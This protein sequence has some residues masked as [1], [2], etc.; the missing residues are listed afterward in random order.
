MSRKHA[1]TLPEVLASLAILGIVALLM[2]AAIRSDE[3]TAQLYNAQYDKVYEDV[4]S[5]SKMVLTLDRNDTMKFGAEE[6][7]DGLRAAFADRL[8]IADTWDHGTGWASSE[9][10]ALSKIGVDKGDISGVT[11]SNGTRI[12]FVSAN[13][14]SGGASGLAS[15]MGWS[16][17]N[18]VGALAVD[19]NGSNPRNSLGNDQSLIPL[20][21]DGVKQDAR[22]GQLAAD[23]TQSTVS[24]TDLSDASKDIECNIVGGE[25]VCSCTRVETYNGQEFP[26]VNI[27]GQCKSDCLNIARNP[28]VNNANAM[29]D[30][31]REDGRCYSCKMS[32]EHECNAK[33]WIF[34]DV[35][36]EC[37]DPTAPCEEPGFERNQTTGACECALTPETCGLAPGEELPE[38][39]CA[40]C[41]AG[42]LVGVNGL[43]VDENEVCGED[44][45]ANANRTGCECLVMNQ[46]CASGF[47]NTDTC[48][49]ECDA[50][51]GRVSNDMTNGAAQCACEGNTACAEHNGTYDD[52]NTCSCNCPAPYIPNGA[53]GAA[54]ACVC[55]MTASGCAAQNGILNDMECKCEPCPVGTYPENG[56]CVKGDN[57]SGDNGNGNGDNG[58]QPGTGGGGG[59]YLPGVCPTKFG[60]SFEIKD[61]ITNVPRWD[62][63]YYC[64]ERGY[65][66]IT[67][68][69][70]L[71][72]RKRLFN[73]C[74]VSS[75]SHSNKTDTVYSCPS[76]S[77]DNSLLEKL[78][79]DDAQINGKYYMLSSERYQYDECEDC[80]WDDTMSGSISHSDNEFH[81]SPYDSYYERYY[82]GDDDEYY[83]EEEVGVAICVE[84]GDFPHEVKNNVCLY[85][86]AANCNA[87]DI[88]ISDARGLYNIRNNLSANYCLVADID[89]AAQKNKIPKYDEAKGWDPIEGP[90]EY[91]YYYDEF[92]YCEAYYGFSGTFNGNGH[93]IS[94]L[95]INRP[96][97]L[98]T[99][100]FGYVARGATIKNLGLANVNVSGA[101]NTG[102]LAGNNYGN[103]T[104]TYVTGKVV[105][106]RPYIGGLVGSNGGVINSSVSAANVESD[107][108]A[109]GGIVGSNFGGETMNSYFTGT[110]TSTSCWIG[111]VAGD[112]YYGELKNSY[113]IGHVYADCDAGGVQGLVTGATVKDS[114]SDSTVQNIPAIGTNNG[115]VTNVRA[116]TTSQ[117][118][119]SKTSRN[120]YKN[121]PSDI[122]CFN[123][124][125]YPVLKDMPKGTPQPSGANSCGR[126]CSCP[127]ASTGTYDECTCIGGAPLYESLDNIC[128]TCAQATSDATPYWNSETHQ[129][130]ACPADKP[131]YNG[132][133][134]LPCSDTAFPIQQG[135]K[136]VSCAS[137]D[138][139]KPYWN[140]TEC[141]ACPNGMDCSN[142]VN[143][144]KPECPAIYK[145]T[146]PTEEGNCG[147]GYIAITTPEQLAQ[148]GNCYPSNAN[149]CL[150]NSIDL[151]NFGSTYDGGE[152][153]LPISGYQGTFDGN[154]HAIKNLYM[155]RH[156]INGPFYGLFEQLRNSTIKN[157]SLLNEY[158]NIIAIKTRSNSVGYIGGLAGSLST[159]TTVERVY[160]DANITLNSMVGEQQSMAGGVAAGTSSSTV[161][162]NVHTDGSVTVN[163]T[164]GGQNSFAG[165]IIG[166]DGGA[167]IS[168][169]RS[170]VNV[171]SVSNG[172]NA[173]A[174][175]IAGW[176]IA[177]NY[178]KS[179]MVNC[180]A[181]GKINGRYGGGVVGYY[182][183]YG[184]NEGGHIE[185]SLYFDTQATETAKG[186]GN[187]KSV[188]A[189]T[190]LTTAQS[191]KTNLDDV[192]TGWSTTDWCF[193]CGDY[194][195]LKNMPEGAP[196]GSA[197]ALQCSTCPSDSWDYG[198]DSSGNLQCDCSFNPQTYDYVYNVS[199]NSTL[200]R[201]D[202]FCPAES[203]GE[204]PDCDC[205]ANTGNELYDNY[206]NYCTSCYSMYWHYSPRWN[207]ETKQCEACP[208]ETPFFSEWDNACITCADYDINTPVWDSN[209]FY[210][211]SCYDA[212]NSRPYWTGT[213]CVSCASV[214]ASKP[215]WNTST[216]EC[217][218]CELSTFGEKSYWNG[219]ECVSCE[220]V[221]STKTAW[222]GSECVSCSS[223]NSSKPGWLINAC[224]T[225]PDSLYPV[226]QGDACVS[227][228]SID[229][230]TPYWNGTECVACLDGVNCSGDVPKLTGETPEGNCGSGYI[231]ITSVAQLAVIGRDSRYPLNGNYCVMND[232]DISSYSESAVG[233]WL[234]IGTSVGS[235]TGTLDGNGHTIN[236]LYI[237]R[238]YP[239]VE[240]Q[241]LIGKTHNAT[242]KN[243][244]LQNVNIA[245]AWA[246]VGGLVGS[247]DST[248]NIINS[249]VSGS[250]TG[251][252][253]VGGLVGGGYYNI[254]NSYST[255]TVV[256]HGSRGGGLVGEL[257]GNIENSFST[258]SVTGV[259]YL[260]GLVGWS[261]YRQATIKDSYATGDIT[262]N[263][264][265]AYGDIGGLVGSIRDGG[266][267]QN[268]YSTGRVVGQNS[269]QGGLLG[270]KNATVTNSYY[271][272]E[273]S[274]QTDTGKGTP[275][276]TA[277]MKSIAADNTYVGWSEDV[278]CFGCSDYPHLK[279]MPEGAPG[280]TL[281]ARSCGSCP[282]GSKGTYPSCSC[283]EGYEYS[284]FA[285][286]CAV[287]C[288]NNGS[289]Y[290]YPNCDCSG[291]DGH[292]RYDYVTN[293]CVSCAVYGSDLPIWNGSECISCASATSAL[294][295]YWDGTQCTNVPDGMEYDEEDDIIRLTAPTDKGYCDA[296]YIAIF[297]AHQM[298]LIGQD[299]R[300][301]L[302]DR[303]C[304]MNDINLG[305]YSS[306]TANGWLPIGDNKNAFT[307]TFDGNMQTISGL[308]I[309]RPST[310]YNG[311]FGRTNNATLKNVIIANADLASVGG[312]YS[313]ILVGYST[314]GSINNVGTSGSIAGA[315]SYV[316]GLVGATSN[317][318]IQKSY[319]TANVT[320]GTYV[321]G[322]IGRYVSNSIKYCY[323]TGDVEGINQ[324]GGFVGDLS[325]HAYYCYALGDVVATGNSA[326][327]GGFA[328]TLGWNLYD[329]FA[330]GNVT[331]LGTGA[332]TQAG[333]L[334]GQQSTQNG[335]VSRSYSTGTVMAIEG[336]I[337]AFI[338]NRLTNTNITA[339]TANYYNSDT[340]GDLPGIGDGN[341]DT[342][343]VTGVPSGVLMS[344]KNPVNLYSSWNA[345]IWCFNC[346][347]YPVLKDMPDG[348][349]SASSCGAVCACPTEATGEY[350]NSD[351]SAYPTCRCS[352]INKKYVYDEWNNICQSC[353]EINAEKPYW[354]GTICSI[355]CEN[356]LY[357]VQGEDECHYCS[358]VDENKPY[359]D[360][361]ECKET[362][363]NMDCTEKGTCTLKG[364][365][366][367]G[368]CGE[369]YIA[370]TYPA[371]LHAIGRHEDYPLDANYCLMKNIDLSA[372]S[373]GEGWEPIG[374][375]AQAFTGIFDGNGKEIS[376]LHIN[377][378]N[379]DYQGLF[380][381]V[382]RATISNLGLVNVDV[383][384][385]SYVGGIS[386]GN[387]RSV[388]D[389]GIK[390]DKCYATGTVNGSS[391]VGG[392][393]GQGYGTFVKISNSYFDGTV[394]GG[395]NVG[396]I[397]GVS[398]YYSNTSTVEKC[399][400]LGSVS[401]SNYVGGITGSGN[402]ARTFFS[403]SVRGSNYVG[404]VSGYGY[405]SSSYA[406]GSVSGNNYVGGISGI[407]NFTYVV[408][409]G[410]Y[411]AARVTGT[412][413]SVG[414]LVGFSY[415]SLP[416]SASYFNTDTTNQTKPIGNS[417][418]EKYNYAAVNT[419]QMYSIP[420]E[421]VY[422]GWSEAIWCFF[423]GDYPVLKG[424]PEGA[425]DVS[426]CA[427]DCENCPP[428]SNGDYPSCSC[429]DD[430]AVYS[431]VKNQC[432]Y[433]CPENMDGKYPKCDCSSNA[434]HEA[435][436]VAEN[437]CVNC[438]SLDPTT[439][440]W[441]GN[442]C[443]SCT[444]AT[445]SDTPYWNGS[446]CSAC[447]NGYECSEVI[448]LTGPTE[449]GYCDAGYIAIFSPEQLL[450]IGIDEHYPLDANYCLMNNINASRGSFGHQFI[451]GWTPIGTYTDK[452]DNNP[453]TGIFDG[454]GNE[455][456]NLYIRN[457]GLERV[458]LFGYITGTVKNLGI[459]NAAI[460]NDKPFAGI[461]AG[462]A[463]DDSVIEN[464]YVKGTIKAPFFVGGMIGYGKIKSMKDSYAE[465]DVTATQNSTQ[466][467]QNHWHSYTR[468]DGTGG[469]IGFAL[470]SSSNTYASSVVIQNVHV[471][472]NVKGT[473]NVGGLIG[474]GK[475]GIKDSYTTCDV[476]G[477][478]TVGGF[479]GNRP[480]GSSGS[481]TNCH[482]TGNVK[483][484][485]GYVGG[486]V[487]YTSW[488]SVSNCY[489]TGDVEGTDGDVGGFAGLGQSISS[490]YATGNVTGKGSNV[491]TGG[492]AGATTIS[493][494][495]SKCFSTGNVVSSGK[496][497]GGF[498]GRII[499]EPN[500]S[501]STSSFDSFAGVVNCYSTGDIDST[502]TY[503]G[504]FAGT[505]FKSGVKYSY[506]LSH[507]NSH[508][509]Y[510]GGFFGL[511]GDAETGEYQ[512]GCAAV[513]YNI[514]NT[515]VVP[516]VAIGSDDNVY[517]LPTENLMVSKN[518]YNQYS[519]WDSGVWCFNCGAY[520][521]L[522]GMPAGAPSTT[523]CDFA[524]S[525]PTGSTGAY[526]SCN[527]ATA[528]TTTPFYN[529]VDNVCEAC[530]VIH[531]EATFWNGTR[532]VPSCASTINPVYSDGEC[533]SCTQ[534]T[535]AETPY[536]NGAECTAC[537][538]NMDC[539]GS[540]PKLTGETPEGNCG[541]G[542]I[543]ISSAGQLSQIGANSNYP[544]SANYCLLNDISLAEFGSNFEGG[545]GWVPI[546]NYAENKNSKFT[547]TFDGNGK[548]ISDIYIYRPK[549]I[550]GM[551]ANRPTDYQGL[552]GYTENA[553][554]KNLTLTGVDITANNTIGA[555]VAYKKGGTITNVS[556]NGVLKGNN[557]IGG[558]AGVSYGDITNAD[559]DIE[560]GGI[561]ANATASSY[562][563]AIAGYLYEGTISECTSSGTINA[564]GGG[565]A[566]YIGTNA[567]ITN[568]HTS[569]YIKGSGGGLVSYVDKTSSVSHSYATGDVASGA[570]FV[571]S[572]SG[573]ISYCYSTGK[574]SSGAGFAYYNYGKISSAFTTGDV[575]GS[576][577]A[578]FVYS[579]GGTYQYYDEQQKKYVYAGYDAEIKDC[580]CTGR[581]KLTNSYYYN[582]SSLSL[583]AFVGQNTYGAKITNCYTISRFSVNNNS[584]NSPE[585]SGGFV[586]RIV[587]NSSY[588]YGNISDSYYNTDYVSKRLNAIGVYPEEYTETVI[589]L[590]S[591]QMSVPK[592][593][594]NPY[595]NWDDSKWCFNCGTFPQLKGMPE[596][597]PAA[598]SCG[599]NCACPD[600][601]TGTYSSC[602]CTRNRATYD[603]MRNEC[604]Y[605]CPYEAAE[606][607][608][609]PA[610]DCSANGGSE[611]FDS[612]LNVCASCDAIN[613]KTPL[614]SAD[615]NECIPCSSQNAATPAWDDVNG[616][617]STCMLATDGQRPKF[618]KVCP[619]GMYLYGDECR[620]PNTPV[621]KF[622]VGSLCLVDKM[623]RY[624][625]ETNPDGFTPIL[626][627]TETEEMVAQYNLGT[628]HSGEDANDYWAG[629]MK[630]C[631]DRGARL[632][633]PNE[634]MEL[635]KAI[636]NEEFSLCEGECTVTNESHTGVQGD[637]CCA[638]R[639]TI[640]GIEMRW[641]GQYEEM[642]DW[643]TDGMWE[644]TY[645]W[646]SAGNSDLRAYRV[647]FD[648]DRFTCSASNRTVTN[649]MALCVA[650]A[651]TFTQEPEYGCYACGTGSHYDEAT[652][653]CICNVGYYGDGD[654]C[655][656]CG[657]NASTAS[658]DSPDSSYCMCNQGY[659]GDGLICDACPSN[660]Y[661]PGG[662]N[663]PTFCDEGTWY[664]EGEC[665]PVC[666]ENAVIINGV[667]KVI[668]QS[669]T[670][671]AGYIGI[672]S[673]QDLAKIGNDSNYPL[674][675]NN[676]KY[677]LMNNISLSE[678]ASG[679][680]WTPIGD[681]ATDTSNQFK[682]IFDGNN[683]VISGLT[684]NRGDS[685]YQ[686][687]F[688]YVS[689]GEI[690][691]LGVN[692][693]RISGK[694]IVGGIAG[695]VAG[696]SI[697]HS[698]V[699]ISDSINSAGSDV[700]SLVG[701]I[702]GRAYGT[703]V[704]N[705]YVKGGSIIGTFNVGGAIG[706]GGILEK[707]YVE[708]VAF[709][710]G[711]G[712]FGFA[713]TV[714]NC[715]VKNLRRAAG[716]TDTI[717][718]LVDNAPQSADI[719]STYVVS[720]SST[721]NYIG[722][723][724]QIGSASG[725]YFDNTVTGAKNA[726]YGG[727]I[728]GITGV[729]TEQMTSIQNDTAYTGWSTDVW[730]FECGDYP[731]LKDMPA[732]APDAKYCATA[733]RG[734]ETCSGGS[735]GANCPDCVCPLANG[736][737]YANANLCVYVCPPGARGDYSDCDCTPNTSTPYYDET[738]NTC[739]T[740]LA[741]YG[742]QKP[743]LAAENTCISCY[744]SNPNAPAWKNDHCV[745]CYEKNNNKPYY[746]NSCCNACADTDLPYQNG[747]GCE[748]CPSDTPYFDGVTCSAEPTNI[749]FSD[750]AW[751]LMAS[752]E[753]GNCGAGYIAIST[754][755]QLAK[756]GVP[757]SCGIVQYP[758][759]DKYCLMNDIN[760]SGRAWVPIA[761]YGAS[762]SN[763]FTGTFDGNNKT[764]SGL[765]GGGASQ[766]RGLFGYNNGTIVNLRVTGPG[767]GAACY[768]GGLA[769][770][771]G[772]SGVI[773]NCSADVPVSAYAG[774]GW[775]GNIAIGGLV[776]TSYGIIDHSFA[777]GS[778]T[779]STT[780]GG[781]LVGVQNSGTIS[782]SYATGRVYSAYDAHYSL[783][784][785]G[786]VAIQDGGT[787]TNCY[788][789]G[790]VEYG[791]KTGNINHTAGSLVGV[792][793]GVI[794][795]SYGLGKV[796]GGSRTSY[797][798]YGGL[799]GRKSGTAVSA[800]YYNMETT[801][802]SDTGRGI[803]LTTAQMQVSKGSSNPYATWSTD[804]WC[805]NDGA[806]P[807]LLN[808][809]A[810]AEQ[811]AS[812]SACG[813]VSTSCPAN[814]TGTYDSCICTIKNQ[815]YD[816]IQNLCIKV[817]PD[818]TIGTYPACV[819]DETDD[820]CPVYDETI[821]DCLSCGEV[822]GDAL[823]DAP[824]CPEGAELTKKGCIK[825]EVVNC[826]FK[827]GNLCLAEL[828]SSNANNYISVK[829]ETD[830]FVEKY[831]LGTKYINSNETITKDYW[832][833]AMKYC[834]DRQM[835]LPTTDEL[836]LIAAEVYDAPNGVGSPTACANIVNSDYAGV[837]N[838]CSASTAATRL[839]NE[840]ETWLRGSI[841]EE[842]AFTIFSNAASTNTSNNSTAY[843]R[844]FS[845]A[846][847]SSSN[848]LR[849]TIRG[850]ILCVTDVSKENTSYSYMVTPVSHSC[851]PC[852]EN[853]TYDYSIQK[854]LCNAG[855]YGN[856]VT[857]STCPVNGYCPGGN[858][859]D[860]LCDNDSIYDTEGN[861]CTSCDALYGEDAPVLGATGC[862][863]CAAYNSAT[864][865]W[866]DVSGTCVAEGNAI[867][868]SFEIIN[869]KVYAPGECEGSVCFEDM[870]MGANYWMAAKDFCAGLGGRLPN[871]I[872]MAE[873]S[874]AMYADSECTISEIGEY[875]MCSNDSA[876]TTSVW[877]LLG[878]TEA[879]LWTNVAEGRNIHIWTFGSWGDSRN[880]ASSDNSDVKAM[881]IIAS[882]E[883]PDCGELEWYDNAGGANRYYYTGDNA[884][885]AACRAKII[886]MRTDSFCTSRG[887]ICYENGGVDG[888]SVLC[889]NGSAPC[890]CQ[891]GE[892][893]F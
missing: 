27:N 310:G 399:Y 395:S 851:T 406:S 189:I 56:N 331:V 34:N 47:Y 680:G 718:G 705:C 31:S 490:S 643:L 290:D 458:G 709:R 64:S 356:Q 561:A 666:G 134:C 123:C 84:D 809:P 548:A 457:S 747:E 42:Q 519:T 169:C 256:V 174:G 845:L 770:I 874:A 247:S 834:Q 668:A 168:D 197:C 893:A 180:I 671:E 58:D 780:A 762:T 727:G 467:I 872:E 623:A 473:I 424:M 767:V 887:D 156:N 95:Y 99:G 441:N 150:M 873:I 43:C 107:T 116:L 149:Y 252:A 177:D 771:N 120:I 330:R 87:G 799:V 724:Q 232:I 696:R 598:N 227:C 816:A 530:S 304:L 826:E 217:T 237:S 783:N 588:G 21:A 691:N 795:K 139:T 590:T 210:C 128:Q 213:E 162:R 838:G 170:D 817:C 205:S 563:G 70:L 111:G 492:F 730:C 272:R 529:V 759:N 456:T 151:S 4:Y 375:S 781:G 403:G 758:L 415:A 642:I 288:P 6:G 755:D 307:G 30:Y 389:D 657:T 303:Y 660:S 858:E 434:G 628:I 859:D 85:T 266:T 342:I 725:V 419:E 479:I 48:S 433:S 777:T 698:Y 502:A 545:A 104:N 54:A 760:I 422:N 308:F 524:C 75:G 82:Y 145:L 687:L 338:G 357:P 728:S 600:G 677:C 231:A 39:M 102:A 9:N 223:L 602:E 203:T 571:Q 468:D 329:S 368:N 738:T 373:S 284:E 376:N 186:T 797:S 589:G 392:L 721:I 878:S 464:V 91:C 564:A 495:A 350:G 824:I 655:I 387:P 516:A 699:I 98:E 614:W 80:Y 675:G 449:K 370:I 358:Y 117:M 405:A 726:Y 258:A 557:N 382:Q 348:A 803:G 418:E 735:A 856:G 558:V 201:C 351:G 509:E 670:C 664:Y 805:F 707:S 181:T 190:G 754:A 385:R 461:L 789:T 843:R 480:S 206:Y 173:V 485:G 854:C 594:N 644:K 565:I 259:E 78:S 124:G 514:D 155:N 751:R 768:A 753:N 686:G 879:V 890:E 135:N 769:S 192:Y 112:G 672:T 774:C 81:Y 626:S 142:P 477:T 808:M 652:D 716:A 853:A 69:Q 161:I 230:A 869:N 572:N 234:P 416:I 133:G 195:V 512:G 483:S 89:L 108:V 446:T 45:H 431:Q 611:A 71:E 366:S 475:I 836:L 850:N 394:S 748:N 731:V 736:T 855:Y 14:V 471:S 635:A 12:G 396:G 581:V 160:I 83:W 355:S 257:S 238:G 50:D 287:P 214:D 115:S 66:L 121:W 105:G 613:K 792:S 344:S 504:G 73:G 167:K 51:A 211:K 132:Y 849:S 791:T 453:F 776:G 810:E 246:W 756:I 367:E 553:T 710:R 427:F 324:V 745:T 443:V 525:C 757:D 113:S 336:K 52:I 426:Y 546:G 786:L 76:G 555:M 364:E 332:N 144:D 390:I 681:Y 633:T 608:E 200:N 301:S 255:G 543:A 119:V 481:V 889:C 401:G 157:L 835:R 369:G 260:G 586:G 694:S 15:T 349:F 411:A 720:P 339:N 67:D 251:E 885:S 1:F 404:G 465:V 840:L 74:S 625:E 513:F 182:Q 582:M 551:F 281:C 575:V 689:G 438:A 305:N 219:T 228:A 103:I 750:G 875:S 704:S 617:C 354:T 886:S 317:T 830:E 876:T 839:D 814:S 179:K 61:V 248:T 734:C 35:S 452:E 447:P 353:A 298:A 383:T 163:N 597:A 647:L 245:D 674:N 59:T 269:N 682:G 268:C 451:K 533:I 270:Y 494:G 299:S 624:D 49:C 62:A 33:S 484:T 86:P 381:R 267:V 619:A 207:N 538:D 38:G 520:P 158:I 220:S 265:Y 501:Y 236:G 650:D 141:I 676:A 848:A 609:Y 53:V 46:D 101:R 591:T 454:N 22:S 322:L 371:Q 77:I 641:D 286:L 607:S 435:Y 832:A 648:Y 576:N 176:Y 55:S 343:E 631:Q 888:N 437:I 822:Y 131:Y 528:G 746:F 153:W 44:K 235:F 488:G 632:A 532:C 866:D 198:R 719:S 587:G 222:N 114:Y 444:Q 537:P 341:T 837:Q 787:I 334:A 19:L 593:P 428:H 460:S 208:S 11:L 566:G 782:N 212:D 280:W 440:V 277:Q 345:N 129:C 229:S 599:T 400:A 283:R 585:A 700:G 384:G 637:V 413:S 199:Y 285:N 773:R 432:I 549:N 172:Q 574:V 708:D 871:D 535:S 233:G 241:G 737:Y 739:S 703:T 191:H 493:S 568:S 187:N 118:K 578:G 794:S 499:P 526:G 722:S 110:V 372:Y 729:S 60:M 604:S 242:I 10:D 391:Y 645:V 663:E 785:G 831:H 264:D 883:E 667:C 820:A 196:D 420:N 573:N 683:K 536:W 297:S 250:I 450:K 685:N 292:N 226:Q 669:G 659:Y 531:P 592:K 503:T 18:L 828:V 261:I 678:Y 29:V 861:V 93:T 688:G 763:I 243:I 612:V 478:S 539:S 510:V 146:G 649:T 466:A 90:P 629:A 701:G 393:L 166:N 472:G 184:R 562:C 311:L 606:G 474:Y 37:I 65:K 658:I 320:G 505:T 541:A 761:Q 788:A 601:S 436:N 347:A 94:N 293:T 486:F 662:G 469:L 489:A 713:G 665:L 844:A 690:R 656:P 41:G 429:T 482:A 560:I 806:Y 547:G 445:S 749:E 818:G 313:G 511:R 515:G 697:N 638:V 521:Q 275:L 559:V 790:D 224:V 616:T 318:S 333:G 833:Y 326:I 743:V 279:N 289:I 362:P 819:V 550:V 253:I 5:A 596:G 733:E 542:Y 122:W 314:G 319:S 892:L 825:T 380:G 218:T 421:T 500:T 407:L 363:D 811:S 523:S 147:A 778:V 63:P 517:G 312:T 567:S 812:T 880:N 744:E 579:N 68:T 26:M 651:G 881:C 622:T 518:N 397:A 476:Q 88:I 556:V 870:G 846:S 159:N 508:G 430:N 316:G 723:Y 352:G 847:T 262:G 692:V 741:M 554:I 278:W 506:T 621:C 695:E 732:G 79:F 109:T 507:I 639:R 779:P 136:C 610:C 244:R 23:T 801:Q 409:S 765:S 216:N 552:F 857:C 137:V 274:G 636:Y 335:S 185:S 378:P 766:H 463:G 92:N 679:E 282:L 661:C 807:V 618:R 148:I 796:L 496:S 580:Y 171:T 798:N 32:V 842:S 410:S 323:A 140:G 346:G 202:F 693:N 867:D 126:A 263:A 138:S 106:S 57:N 414:G 306:N 487:G 340:A 325:G 544:L 877:G 24:C 498:A 442:A 620:I 221:D 860:V 470:P 534:A 448:K 711:G 455:I 100:L 97:E 603:P 862:I 408:V 829:D 20:Y 291:E 417:N 249:S 130:E 3:N 864:P 654:V 717:S 254:K 240:S 72:L 752:L 402:L 425:P 374:T 28:E 302:S 775:M 321:G 595:A 522:K 740:C 891:N 584:D 209:E 125:N 423:C 702:V 712:L 802:Q 16:A 764:I 386:G 882:N 813:T 327:A 439:P 271:D 377:R 527:C 605:N 40:C 360:G 178:Y 398:F 804:D 204:Y 194:P 793:S 152:G 127:A 863:S 673:A 273:T 684:I 300:Y 884:A 309:N 459:V 337:G 706:I 328:G 361:A 175:G 630:Y 388:T 821:N 294:T 868:L 852:D 569:A 17:D 784:L 295:P 462:Q 823:Y 25:C 841:S 8:D 653:R 497:A 615:R 540:V 225:C 36:C 634:I 215:V 491:S 815:E 7:S 715:Y 359:Y 714:Q 276:T 315:G 2:L 577:T 154:G 640:D 742:E 412:G 96:D 800:S 646:T 772:P 379:V 827:I 627:S 164:G 865:V 13:N 188:D 583:G 193:S 239:G 570:G 296:G 365:T 165:G 143:P 183:D